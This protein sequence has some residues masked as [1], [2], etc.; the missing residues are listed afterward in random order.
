M[1]DIR[2]DLEERLRNL[3]LQIGGTNAWFDQRVEQLKKE[4]DVKLAE[5]NSE[6]DAV[7]KVLNLERQRLGATYAQEP[8]SP[9]LGGFEG[10]LAFPPLR[11]LRR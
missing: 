9:K 4:R 8:S 6:V 3:E 5:L 2:Q 1:R 11:E 10:N 7:N